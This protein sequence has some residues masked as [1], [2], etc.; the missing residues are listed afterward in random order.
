[1]D[2]SN[3]FVIIDDFV[4]EECISLGETGSWADCRGVVREYENEIMLYV[5]KSEV[6]DFLEK[7]NLV[8]LDEN[9]YLDEP[10]RVRL[11]DER[12]PCVSIRYGALRAAVKNSINTK[13][14]DGQLTKK[15][16]VARKEIEILTKDMAKSETTSELFKEVK[17]AIMSDASLKALG[18]PFNVSKSTS[19]INAGTPLLFLSDWHWAE[20]VDPAQIEYLNEYNLDIAYKRSAR[21][22][23]TSLDLLFNHM[24]GQ[25]YDGVVIALGGDM[26][27]GNIHEEL[28]RTNEVPM[29]DAVKTLAIE[30]ARGIREYAKHF[31]SVYV[32]CVVGNHGRFD[33]KPTAKNKACDNF[34]YMVYGFVEALVSDLKNVKIDIST[35]SD[36]RFDIY[37]TKYLMTHGDQIKGGAGIGG[38]WP[39]MM[40]AEQLKRKRSQLGGKT[41]F[42]YMLVGHFHTYGAV[43]NVIVNGSLKSTDEYSYNGNFGHQPPIQAMWITHPQHGITAHYPI[44]GNESK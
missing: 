36:I 7:D 18:S 23:N 9:G 37:D 27:S 42:D 22:F 10:R 17:S 19:K 11:N 2:V 20:V 12:V 33:K 1:M 43:D 35:A 32:P 38:I 41:G 28:Q 39:S 4:N 15:L 6:Y 31:K 14:K 29:A 44:L 21:V 40:K 26:L 8:W 24:S 16:S 13:V 34:D 25:T 30:L 5:P 3:I